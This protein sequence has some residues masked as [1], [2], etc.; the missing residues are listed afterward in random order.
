M[1]TLRISNVIIKDLMAILDKAIKI[2]DKVDLTVDTDDNSI[3]IDPVFKMIDIST[4]EI[5]LTD[6]LIRLLIKTTT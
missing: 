2:G 1:A 6:E 4:D 3:T 5:E